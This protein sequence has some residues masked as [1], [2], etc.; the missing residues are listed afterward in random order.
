MFTVS[1]PVT[2]FPKVYLRDEESRARVNFLPVFLTEGAGRL[3]FEGLT[4][5]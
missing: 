1:F 4:G 5:P 3:G 2:G